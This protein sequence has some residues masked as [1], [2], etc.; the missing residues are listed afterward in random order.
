MTDRLTTPSDGERELMLFIAMELGTPCQEEPMLTS[1]RIPIGEGTLPL[2]QWDETYPKGTQNIFGLFEEWRTDGFVGERTF[3]QDYTEPW[4]I[5]TSQHGRVDLPFRRVKRTPTLPG[6]G[7]RNTR[8]GSIDLLL[9]L[10]SPMKPDIMIDGRLLR[11]GTKIGQRG[12]LVES[13]RSPHLRKI[14]LH[15]GHRPTWTYPE[16]ELRLL[17]R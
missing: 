12:V 11:T 7:P 10:K 4:F 9:N 15:C 2:L 1:L 6:I 5:G 3:C 14:G 13:E 8:E 17:N 16:L